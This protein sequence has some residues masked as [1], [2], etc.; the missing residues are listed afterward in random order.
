MGVTRHV[1]LVRKFD[2]ITSHGSGLFVE[3]LFCPISNERLRYR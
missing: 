1:G 2:W 3:F